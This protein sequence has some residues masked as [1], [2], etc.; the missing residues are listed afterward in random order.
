MG[1]PFAERE[2]LKKKSL[3]AQKALQAESTADSTTPADKGKTESKKPA[4]KKTQAKPAQTKKNPDAG[5]TRAAL[6]KPDSIPVPVNDFADGQLREGL[7]PQKKELL[8]VR[9]TFLFPESLMSRVDAVKE[10]YG[11]RSRNELV[12]ELLKKAL[13]GLEV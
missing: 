3:L 9:C 11:F 4:V 2:E 10:T 1:N 13:D 6:S 5:S 7:S 12:I 8:D